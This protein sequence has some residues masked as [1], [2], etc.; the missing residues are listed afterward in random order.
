MVDLELLVGGRKCA[1]NIHIAV[2]PA[3]IAAG[4]DAPDAEGIAAVISFG[5]NAVAATI[6]G[7]TFHAVTPTGGI[8]SGIA[9]VRV[10]TILLTGK[11]SSGVGIPDTVHTDAVIASAIYAHSAAAGYRLDSPTVIGTARKYPNR[12][13][14]RIEPLAVGARIGNRKRGIVA[15]YRS[16]IGQG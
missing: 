14:L 8:D 9:G 12:P 13:S 6:S 3:R 4:A 16:R 1:R 5:N 15:G 11:I 10:N 7:F 2:K